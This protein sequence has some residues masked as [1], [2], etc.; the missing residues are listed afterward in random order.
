MATNPIFALKGK[1]TK[2]KYRFK[3]FFTLS[4][5]VISTKLI[6]CSLPLNNIDIYIIFAL[7]YPAFSLYYL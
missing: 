2:K 7:T 1:T 3:D 6:G 4:I 5:T